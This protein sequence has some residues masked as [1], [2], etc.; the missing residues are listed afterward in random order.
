[1][2]RLRSLVLMLG[3]LP[4][5]L[6]PVRSSDMGR[7][8]ELARAKFPDV[9][10]ISTE[11]LANWLAATDRL[12]P[13]LIDA[14]SEAEFQVSHLRNAVRTSSV[15]EVTTL[16]AV[17]SGGEARPVVVYCAV[18]YR[19]SAFVQK[20]Q[21][22]GLTEVFSLDGSIFQWANEGRELF[23]DNAPVKVVHPYDRKWGGLLK[24]EYR[25]D[26]RKLWRRDGR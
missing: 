9:K 12:L 3:L 17:D 1:M 20:L 25:A 10:P 14:R 23:R 13:L 2:M 26:L 19:A 22:A 7:I 4:V 15:Q 11:T 21:K 5:M 8:R 16:V 6:R 24:P 18:G